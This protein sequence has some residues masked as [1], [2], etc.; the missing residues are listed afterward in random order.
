MVGMPTVFVRLTGCPLRCG[1]C[2]T[3]YAFSGGEPMTLDAICERVASYG[4]ERVTVTGGEPLAQVRCL[5][6][7]TRLCDDEYLVALETSGSLDLSGVDPRVTKIMD[8]KTPGSG[9]VEKN[10]LSNIGH[11]SHSDQIKF[12][13]CDEAD[14]IWS[15][16]IIEQEALVDCVEI[17]MLPAYGEQNPVDLA[18]WILRDRLPVRFQMQLHK[19]LWGDAKGK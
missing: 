8:I 7:L 9:E 15:R 18:E 1:Y 4:C 3:E 17:I 19:Q 12:V 11:L 2:D 14:Y 6:L 16:Q 10:M 13:I 5:E